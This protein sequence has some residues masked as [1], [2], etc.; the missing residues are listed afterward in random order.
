MFAFA[1][2]FPCAL[3]WVEHQTMV[4]M[5]CSAVNRKSFNAGPFCWAPA[6]A[7]SENNPLSE[8]L[9]PSLNTDVCLWLSDINLNQNMKVTLWKIYFITSFKMIFPY[10]NYWWRTSQDMV[11]FMITARYMVLF[12]IVL[13]DKLYWYITNIFYLIVII[14]E[15]PILLRT[16]L[17][18]IEFKMPPGETHDS[19]CCL[20]GL[21]S[22][23]P[24]LFLLN[25]FDFDYIFQSFIVTRLRIILSLFDVFLYLFR[26]FDL[27]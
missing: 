6:A 26:M 23:Q 27:V 15:F 7:T 19:G 18:L 10:L 14:I 25:L 2:R 11:S 22:T 20:N 9:F 17:F 3:M 1:P 24:P 12:W 16:R 13:S 4:I 21:P 8:R 5:R